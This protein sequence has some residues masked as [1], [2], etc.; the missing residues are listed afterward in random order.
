MNEISRILRPGGLLYALTPCYPSREAFQDPTHV[1]FITEKTHVYFTGS[2]PLGRMYGFT[3]NFR[4]KRCEWV[5]FKDALMADDALTLHRRWRRF[6]YR[7][8]GQL[9]HLLW[10]FECDK[11]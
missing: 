2:K 1:N 3:G 6:N 9:A 10:E 8:K 7:R 4:L 5:V 11:P